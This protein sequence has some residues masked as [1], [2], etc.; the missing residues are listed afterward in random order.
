MAG[1]TSSVKRCQSRCSA[2]SL[3]GRGRARG[4][5]DTD[6]AIVFV[7][8][9]PAVACPSERVEVDL[10]K[11]GDLDVA[12]GQAVQIGGSGSR[13]DGMTREPDR[14]RSAG[15][16]LRERTARMSAH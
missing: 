4:S 9:D 7:N 12:G 10:P 1:S 16:M 14:T 11:V 8:D 6:Q 5:E 15:F 13:G 2:T 3:T